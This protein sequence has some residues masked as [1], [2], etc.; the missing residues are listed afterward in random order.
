MLSSPRFRED[1]A[2]IYRGCC[3]RVPERSGIQRMQV[4]LDY[5]RN[6]AGTQ[7]ARARQISSVARFPFSD[8]RR[9]IECSS[10]GAQET[11]NAE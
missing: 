6:R 9:A 4:A 11:S 7:R 1:I 5:E 2:T 8:G 3:G 10:A